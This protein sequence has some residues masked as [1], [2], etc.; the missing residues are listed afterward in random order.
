MSRRALLSAHPCGPAHSA[1]KYRRSIPTREAWGCSPTQIQAA[2]RASRDSGPEWQPVLQPVLCFAT[3]REMNERGGR[4]TEP[5]TLPA[6]L[7]QF[8]P[9]QFLH[10]HTNLTQRLRNR[11][12]ED[13][14]NTHLPHFRQL[15]Q[16]RCP[17][18][19]HQQPNFHH[20]L[21]ARDCS[22]MRQECHQ[23]RQQSNSESTFSMKKPSRTEHL[24][25]D[26]DQTA[27]PR[28]R[29]AP[30]GSRTEERSR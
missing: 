20:L 25:S 26:I 16:R 1:S 29:S 23:K 24:R 28:A 17:M 13:L 5:C 30:I 19:G 7:V 12:A 4:L 8:T 15:D 11:G 14:G 27:S 18:C 10:R 21:A 6:N 2:A 3:H 22:A 9:K